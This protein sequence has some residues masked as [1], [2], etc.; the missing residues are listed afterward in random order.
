MRFWAAR[1][2][3]PLPLGS[4]VILCEHSCKV[5]CFCFPLCYLGAIVFACC[6]KTT[7]S[8]SSRVVAFLFFYFQL[9]NKRIKYLKLLA[10]Y[11][12]KCFCRRMGVV[13]V[14]LSCSIESS[15]CLVLNSLYLKYAAY[16]FF[17]LFC[18]NMAFIKGTNNKG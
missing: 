13:T 10:Y 12:I 18:V 7:A 14:W 8:S 11:F 16:F 5:T 6:S 4:R 1:E 15:N 2:G 3:E 17:L 9:Y